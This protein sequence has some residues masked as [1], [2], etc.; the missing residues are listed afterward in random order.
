MVGLR[1][2]A[3]TNKENQQSKCGEI[4]NVDAALDRIQFRGLPLTVLICSIV[5][6]ALDGFDIQVIGFVSPTLTAE[7]G[8]KRE[9]LASALAAS[10]IGMA[11]GAIGVGPIGDRVGR[12]T[13]L[14]ASVF[15]FGLFT[16]LGSTSSSLPVLTF[17]RFLT[18]VGL[19]GALPNTTALMVEF[20]PPRWRS[21]AVAAAVLGVPVGGLIGAAITA[22]LLPMLGW[23]V[24]FALGG[25]LPLLWFVFLYFLMPESPRYLATRQDKTRELAAMLNR[26]DAKFRYTDNETYVLDSSARGITAGRI[27]ALFSRDLARDTFAVWI[28][29]STNVFAI[30]AFFNWAPTALTALGL[31]L[32]TAVRGALVFNLAGVVGGLALSWVISR[33]GSRGPLVFCATLASG[34][35]FYLAWI[36]QARSADTESEISTA[37]LMA[38]IAVAGFTISSIQVGMYIVSAH[39]YSTECRA[40]GVGWALGIGRLGG[41][42]SSFGGALLLASQSRETGFFVGIAFVL[43]ATSL[44]LLVLRR[45][46]LPADRIRREPNPAM[47]ESGIASGSSLRKSPGECLPD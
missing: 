42:L 22:P 4:V 9:A 2:G 11:V 18:G 39:I 30:Y 28:I 15:L 21:Q 36:A 24:M 32:A 45:H 46:I 1:Y 17:W 7:F 33:F 16:L 37:A 13:A 19:G 27:G 38:G 8:V 3:M 41:I 44:G 23:R 6:L 12:R 34:S 35:L 47:L 26:I 5:T 31:G 25:V 40:A 20:S 43:L 10:S 29:F 14:L